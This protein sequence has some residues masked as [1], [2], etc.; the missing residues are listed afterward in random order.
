MPGANAVRC[1]SPKSTK[2]GPASKFVANLDAGLIAVDDV[3]QWTAQIYGLG[4]LGPIWDLH[5]DSFNLDIIGRDVTAYGAAS[6]RI[7]GQIR[8]LFYRYKT[9]GG[10]E[11]VADFLIGPRVGETTVGTLP[12]DSGTIWCEDTLLDFDQAKAK[13]QAGNKAKKLRPFAIQWGGQSL[14]SPGEAQAS[15]A[16]ALATCL[17]TVCRE[18]DVE[19][20]P[21]WNIGHPETWG[22]VGH[23]KVGGLACDRIADKTLADLFKLNRDRIAYND[24]TLA[25]GLP[26][27]KSG[28]FAPLAD[29][30]DLVWRNTRKKDEFNHF[31][32]MDQECT[33]SG[34]FEGETLLS[35]TDKKPKN[36][37]PDVWNAFYDA[38]SAKKRGALPFRVWQM[39]DEMVEF[40]AKDDYEQFVCAGG[41][42]AHYVGDACQPLHISEF[43]HG[44]PN[45]GETG[46]HSSYETSMLNQHAA[47]MNAAVGKALT[48]RPKVKGAK[49]NGHDAAVEVVELMRRTVGRLPPLEVVQAYNDTRHRTAAMWDRLG[50]RTAACLIDGSETLASLWS[51]AWMTGRKNGGHHAALPKKAFDEAKLMKLYNDKTFL[52][53]FKLQELKRAGDKLVPK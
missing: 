46:V 19:L 26:A 8:A 52:E 15:S 43:H 6:G 11:Y 40:A 9:V 2:A 53:S 32:D 31:A 1:P 33:A 47:E 14:L 30:A 25:D 7:N 36:V 20:I 45:K 23:F 5:V 3:T 4:E 12:G 42:M 39:Y 51:S 38:I 44:R 49:K 22:A 18:L 34:K 41:L 35:L 50:I 16:F 17:S 29:V 37:D 27:H 24:K 48:G 10:F 13:G 28:D 21:N